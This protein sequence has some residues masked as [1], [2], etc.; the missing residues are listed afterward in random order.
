M[1]RVRSM[2]EP[3]EYGSSRGDERLATNQTHGVSHF[4]TSVLRVQGATGNG[5]RA[6]G[7]VTLVRCDRGVPNSGDRISPT[8]CAWSGANDGKQLGK[9]MRCSI[10]GHRQWCG[11]AAGTVQPRRFATAV[12]KTAGA[13]RY[14]EA[15]RRYP[16]WLAR[17]FRARARSLV[18]ESARCCARWRFSVESPLCPSSVPRWAA[19][20][21]TRRRRSIT[22]GACMLVMGGC[23]MGGLTEA[24]IAP[25]IGIA[26]AVA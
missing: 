7:I 15:M 8:G 25:R 19:A 17:L 10:L 4:R 6:S 20:R 24:T 21:R 3:G 14:G 12:R 13:L 9:R 2:L 1:K 5:R 16:A 23:A 26:P 18:S 11:R 22:R